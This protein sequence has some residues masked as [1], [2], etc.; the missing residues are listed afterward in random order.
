MEKETLLVFGVIAIA[1]L[2]VGF[3]AFS[4]LTAPLNPAARGDNTFFS[5]E[6]CQQAGFSKEECF[7]LSPGQLKKVSR[8]KNG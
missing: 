4:W 1:L 5:L 8:Q 2:V 7:K 6:E 3:I